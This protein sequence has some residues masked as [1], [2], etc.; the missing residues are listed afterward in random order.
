ML[1]AFCDEQFAQGLAT[2]SV[3]AST[4]FAEFEATS[5]EDLGNNAELLRI[6]E[7][8]LMTN[9]PRSL[10]REH[11]DLVVILPAK[12]AAKPRRKRLPTMAEYEAFRAAAG[13]WKD[14]DTDKLIAGIDADRGIGDRPPVDG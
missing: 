9:E 1:Q 11:E 6:V 4:I 14:V 7:E 3:D 12:A 5:A 2:T 13:G 10:R 8:V